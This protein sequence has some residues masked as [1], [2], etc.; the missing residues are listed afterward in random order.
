MN[1]EQARHN[2]IKQQIRTWEVLDQPVLDLFNEVHR[3][4]FMPLAYRNLAFADIPIPLQ[5]DQFTLNPKIEARLLQSL[6]IKPHESIL[7]IGTGCAYLTVLLAKLAKQVHSI[8]LF[9]DFI[10][11]ATEK[12]DNMGCNNITLTACDAYSLLGQTQ[13]YDVIVMTASMPI[14]DDRFLELL[15]T[16]GR[17]FV[18]VGDSPAMEARLITKKEAN[19]WSYQSLFET[20]LPALIGAQQ[21]QFFTF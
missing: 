9:A 11:T 20:E 13:R 14:F 15:N 6:A 7:E 16:N 10:Q 1:I 21:K 18:I 5:H 19:S 8:D 12:I 3:E 17:L 2:M 4:D